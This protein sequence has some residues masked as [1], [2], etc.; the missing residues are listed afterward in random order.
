MSKPKWLQQEVQKAVE[1]KAYA[2]G[3]P[4]TI[5]VLIAEYASELITTLYAER[6]K[7]LV[8]T[9]LRPH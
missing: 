8:P 3:V 1:R 6:S 5:S 7:K 2:H 9:T 4:E